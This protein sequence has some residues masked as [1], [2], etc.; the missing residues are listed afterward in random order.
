MAILGKCKSGIVK[1]WVKIFFFQLEGF[2]GKKIVFPLS[3]LSL[4]ISFESSPRLLILKITQF[5]VIFHE[6]LTP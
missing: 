3:F 4:H 5:K 2:S 1:F 6:I